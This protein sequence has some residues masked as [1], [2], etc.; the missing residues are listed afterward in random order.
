MIP[1]TVVKIETVANSVSPGTAY[2]RSCHDCFDYQA[3]ECGKSGMA[4]VSERCMGPK[5]T[6]DARAPE[7]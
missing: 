7:V 4:R 2:N 5:A 3:V 1:G 6:F